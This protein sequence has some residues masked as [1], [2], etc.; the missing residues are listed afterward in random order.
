MSGILTRVDLFGRLVLYL[1]LAH[2]ALTVKSKGKIKVKLRN[3]RVDFDGRPV[4]GLDFGK[5]ACWRPIE[6]RIVKVVVGISITGVD[7]NVSP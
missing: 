6:K 7:V 3:I 5:V 2:M 4:L 1:G